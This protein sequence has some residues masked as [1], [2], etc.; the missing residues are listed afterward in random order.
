M[1]CG[2][3]DDKGLILDGKGKGGLGATT[4]PAEVDPRTLINQ[5]GDSSQGNLI[6]DSLNP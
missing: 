2:G 1:T 6:G 5:N 4:C 3:N